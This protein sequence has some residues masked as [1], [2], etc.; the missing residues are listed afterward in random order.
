[1]TYPLTKAVDD[2]L[3]HNKIFGELVA[4]CA[5]DDDLEDLSDLTTILKEIG[6]Y[7]HYNLTNTLI[8][9]QISERALNIGEGD[10]WTES[11]IDYKTAMKQNAALEKQDAFVDLKASIVIHEMMYDQMRRCERLSSRITKAIQE[12]VKYFI[13]H[14]T[15]YNDARHELGENKISWDEVR[16]P[17]SI[18]WQSVSTDHHFIALSSA[19]MLWSKVNNGRKRERPVN[20]IDMVVAVNEYSSIES[21]NAVDSFGNKDENNDGNFDNILHEI[22]TGR[23]VSEFIESANG[24]DIDVDLL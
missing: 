2:V 18:F 5:T 10:R 20:L 21:S 16:K 19:E 4:L 3:E 13:S 1:M 12:V 24:G 15:R 17:D 6:T 14:L 7:I 22:E 9:I 23:P 8:Y 11:S